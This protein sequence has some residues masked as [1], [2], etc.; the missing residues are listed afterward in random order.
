MSPVLK[1]SYPVA[2]HTSE[3]SKATLIAVNHY[4]EHGRE[5]QPYEQQINVH[6]SRRQDGREV[7]ALPRR[8]SQQSGPKLD[9]R[10]VAELAAIAAVEGQLGEPL[11]EDGPVLGVEFDPLPPGA[12]DTSIEPVR[13]AEP[14]RPRKVVGTADGLRHD[15]KVRDRLDIKPLKSVSSEYTTFQT[16]GVKRKAMLQ[17]A[18]PI[19]PSQRGT[20]APHEYQFIPEQPTGT[21]FYER[22]LLPSSGRPLEMLPQPKVTSLVSPGSFLHGSELFPTGKGYGFEN[23]ASTGSFSFLPPSDSRTSSLYVSNDFSREHMNQREALATFP[24]EGQFGAVPVATAERPFPGSEKLALFH[25]QERA[26]MEKKRKIEE[27]RLAKE[28]EA[29]E[30]HIRREIEK[31]DALRRKHEEKMRKEIEKQDREKK[32]EEK[33]LT[34]EKLREEE[35]LQRELKRELERRE[36]L[37]QKE[38]QRAENERR[39]EE[40]R[41][42]KEAARMKAAFERATAKKLAKDSKGSMDDEELELMQAHAMIAQGLSLIQPIAGASTESMDPYEALITKRFPPPS[43][44]MK[45]PFSVSPWIDSEENISKLFMIWRFLTTFA[46]VIELWPFTVDELAQAF[47]DYDSRLLNEI[48]LALL[49]TLMKDV[50]EAAQATATG[51]GGSN[52]ATAIAAGGHP[53]IVEAAYAWGF[54]IQEWGQLAHPLTWPEIIRQ[55]SLAAGFGP[56]WKRRKYETMP[57]KDTIEVN[58]GE[59][60]VATLRSGAAAAN[61]VALM[62]GKCAGPVGRSRYRLTPGTVKFAAFH[63]LSLEGDK[64]LSILEVADRIQ[65]SGLRDLTSKTPEASISAALSRDANLFERVA[66]S[67]YSVRPAFR[68]DPEYAKEILQ[69]A[70]EKIRVYQTD[71]SDSEEAD[72][73]A[74]DIDIDD[75]S[76]VD[77]QDIEDTEQEVVENITSTGKMALRLKDGNALH[78]GAGFRKQ[79]LPETSSSMPKHPFSLG[80]SLNQDECIEAVAIEN[81][82][83]NDDIKERL[84]FEEEAAIDESQ[85]GEPWVQGLMEGEYANLSVEERLNA[86]VTLVDMINEGSTIRIAL[87]ERYESAS[88]LKRQ[89]WEEVQ[90]DK[91]RFKEQLISKS[92]PTGNDGAKSEGGPVNFASD[93]QQNSLITAA[94]RACMPVHHEKKG[95]ESSI[96]TPTFTTKEIVEAN[97]SAPEVETMTDFTAK[98][99]DAQDGVSVHKKPTPIVEFALFERSRAQIKAEIRLRAEKLYVFRSL[100]LGCDRRRNRYWHFVTS[101]GGQDPGSDRI[102][103]ESQEDGHWE[104]ID[105]EEAFDSLMSSL[106]TRGIREFHLHTVLKKLKGTL[107]QGMRSSSSNTQPT[108]FSRSIIK[109]KGAAMQ[110]LLS[111]HGKCSIDSRLMTVTKMDDSPPSG[112]SGPGNDMLDSPG[113]IQ[114]ELSH[115]A[116]EKQRALDR[117][118]DMERWL[119]IQCF[120]A[121]SSVRAIRFGERREADLLNSCDT[122]HDLYWQ[123][124]KHCPCCHI[125]A[126]I[127]KR[128]KKFRQHVRECEEQ[129][130]RKDLGWKMHGPTKVLPP[131]TQLLMKILLSIEAA[132][133]HEALKSYW[134]ENRKSWCGKLKRACTPG[135]LLEV[136]LE[137]ESAVEQEWLSSS[138]ET[139]EEILKS[140]S[141]ANQTDNCGT[142]ER[143]L[144][145]P[146]IPQTTAAVALRIMAFDAA[147]AYNTEQK[148]QHKIVMKEHQHNEN[149]FQMSPVASSVPVSN[150]DADSDQLL[151]EDYRDGPGESH[152][153]VRGRG[154]GHGRCRMNNRGGSSTRNGGRHGASKRKPQFNEAV[155][156][157]SNSQ[158]VTQPGRGRGPGRPR[159]RPGR[160]RVRGTQI[161]GHK[162]LRTEIKER[163]RKR[164]TLQLS[165]KKQAF[166]DHVNESTGNSEQEASDDWDVQEQAGNSQPSED[167][168][169]GHA[170]PEDY[171]DDT[172]EPQND[173]ESEDGDE[174]DQDEDD[175]RE[176]DIEVTDEQAADDEDDEVEEEEQE[177][178]E[179]VEEPEVDED[180][181]LQS[182]SS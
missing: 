64:G 71:L 105:S 26:R 102:Y 120:R 153:Q 72:K 147:L 168:H 3:V 23:R 35:R 104:V 98:N 27:A 143:A 81:S 178:E 88:A 52:H 138:Y 126:D 129:M 18:P 157:L 99:L 33:R 53:R 180:E 167:E 163:K 117:H 5:F 136:F 179:E 25:E 164:S 119:W 31:Q 8:S 13:H 10:V 135:E 174:E 32:K 128:E 150:E 160:G 78:I 2:G 151:P 90:L 156:Q 47:H 181:E 154:R 4:S 158:Q 132:I 48:H 118:R 110:A 159:G 7:L 50:K 22:N 68:K 29:R 175:A 87:E 145:L 16:S 67:T 12:F 56:K 109:S 108:P 43:V 97:K 130:R 58:E 76:E 41:K 165:I 93:E 173:D 182:S 54:D 115:T 82:K 80:N 65:K 70:R 37:Q 122:C 177:D 60:V 34:R 124:E 142:R 20:R 166:S 92:Q 176:I 75:D 44:I 61:A 91:R 131:R 111:E 11:R 107:R 77:E 94:D 149:E 28:I 17:G 24:L 15:M 141:S 139:A 6:Y 96:P 152:V 112:I 146:W 85:V 21:H 40:V 9:P 123:K 172:D 121:D 155:G 162:Q 51:A 36:R 63:V 100:P 148:E 127:Y 69:A 30:K 89:L 133:P 66:P 19:A 106:D 42:E 38:H 45:K 74:E 101:N 57:P 84:D 39:K 169:H 59:D 116:G 170:R 125:T 79:K 73:D 83:Q 14:V 46:D 114:V 171:E 86:L 113:A 49:K 161:S 140:L 103:Y 62:Q 95:A 134:T 1:E 144:F 55:F 137:L